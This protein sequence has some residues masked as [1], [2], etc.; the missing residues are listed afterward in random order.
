LTF[1]L[2]TVAEGLFLNLEYPDAGEEV[3]LT[4]HHPGI[5]QSPSLLKNTVFDAVSTSHSFDFFFGAPHWLAW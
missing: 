2:F 1:T 3:F 4:N 5:Q